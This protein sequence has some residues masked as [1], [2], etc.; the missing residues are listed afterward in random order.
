MELRFSR[1]IIKSS[2]VVYRTEF[3]I[4]FHPNVTICCKSSYVN[5]YKQSYEIEIKAHGIQGLFLFF[6]DRIDFIFVF[7]PTIPPK[8]PFI[9]LVRRQTFRCYFVYGKMPKE[10]NLKS[11]P[12]LLKDCH[13]LINPAL[14]AS[15]KQHHR[16][17][18]ALYSPCRLRI[19]I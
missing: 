13:F 17:S 7:R 9:C 3:N 8:E 1:C 18:A 6:L 16:N 10:R 4:D 2:T 15:A 11:K 5:I 14:S 12:E 19:L